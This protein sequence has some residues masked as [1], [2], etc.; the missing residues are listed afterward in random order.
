MA[1][2]TTQARQLRV[3]VFMRAP[4]IRMRH[5][6]SSTPRGI[7]PSSSCFSSSLF[8]LW[9]QISII[10]NSALIG[11]NLLPQLRTDYDCQMLRSDPKGE[12]TRGE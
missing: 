11:T 9:G 3:N 12:Q 1:A 8:L 7:T 5:D 6:N 10:D 4:I 2:A